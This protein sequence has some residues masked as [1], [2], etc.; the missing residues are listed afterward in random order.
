MS[1]RT[2]FAALLEAALK[3]ARDW[4]VLPYEDDLDEVTKATVLVSLQGF[5]RHPQ[6]PQGALLERYRVRLVVPS[7]D[8][9]K[10]AV[11]LDDRGSELVLAIEDMGPSIAWQD[12]NK[13]LHRERYLALDLDVTVTATRTPKLTTD[14]T[15][16]RKR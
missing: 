11:Q 16:T 14:P 13:V 5:T 15:T 4:T 12:A 10:R 3:P 6:A 1:A 8:A 9:A 7:E 2:D